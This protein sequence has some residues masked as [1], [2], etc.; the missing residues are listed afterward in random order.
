MPLHQG[1]GLRG[2]VRDGVLPL[3]EIGLVA[4][5]DSR[6]VSDSIDKWCAHPDIHA[7]VR[8]KEVRGE[9]NDSIITKLKIVPYWR[10]VS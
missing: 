9:Q 8:R 1:I 10:R 7:L 2:A 6:E 3:Q 4:V 5:V